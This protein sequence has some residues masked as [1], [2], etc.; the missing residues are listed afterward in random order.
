M[1]GRGVFPLNPFYGKH[2]HF[3]I[4][5]EARL[6]LRRCEPQ[7]IISGLRQRPQNVYTAPVQAAMTI[8]SVGFTPL[9]LPRGV[10]S[11]PAAVLGN[12]RSII[13]AVRSGAIPGGLVDKS[14]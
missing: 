7:Q 3:R 12:S 11:G 14:G 6:G 5:S 8:A 9:G 4:K 1:R 10:F 2:R 13:V